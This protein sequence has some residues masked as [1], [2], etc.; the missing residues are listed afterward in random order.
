[1]SFNLKTST[2]IK[3]NQLD[4]GYTSIDYYAFANR[5]QLQ[6]QKSALRGTFDPS[7]TLTLDLLIPKFEAFVLAP[8]SISG[9]SLVKICQNYPR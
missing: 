2:Q 6:C 3:K 1:M 9:E 5:R 8:K 7:M 4:G